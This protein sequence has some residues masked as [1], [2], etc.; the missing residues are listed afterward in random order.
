MNR[1]QADRI[2]RMADQWRTEI[3]ALRTHLLVCCN[4]DCY[5]SGTDL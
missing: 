5:E 3:Q 2:N 1:R 4:S